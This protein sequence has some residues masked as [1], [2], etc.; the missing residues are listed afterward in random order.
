MAN[1]LTTIN[2]I[3][4]VCNY[5]QSIITSF[6][7]LGYINSTQKEELSIKIDA[8]K[9]ACASTQMTKLFEHNLECLD[10]ATKHMTG[11]NFTGQALEAAEK[12]Y[13]VLA[14]ALHENLVAFTRNVQSLM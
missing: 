6:R 12:E 3:S 9:K 5:A 11:K 10:R 7:K 2:A 14:N 13:A 1:E 4:S 8:A